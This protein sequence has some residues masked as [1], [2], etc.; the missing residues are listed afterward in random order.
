MRA[1]TGPDGSG[2]C[3]YAGVS[4]VGVRAETYEGQV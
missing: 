3:E 2:R 4:T 1:M